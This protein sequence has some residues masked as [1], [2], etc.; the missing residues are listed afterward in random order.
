M[1]PF[2]IALVIAIGILLLVAIIVLVI[3]I[4]LIV[5]SGKPRDEDYLDPSVSKEKK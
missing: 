4:V 3:F 1:S 5:D 2:Q